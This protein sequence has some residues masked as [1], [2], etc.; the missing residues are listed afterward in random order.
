MGTARRYI[1]CVKGTLQ[2]FDEW[3]GPYPYDRITLVDPPHGGLRAGGMEYPDPH[4]SGH[5]VVHAQVR[6]RARIRHRT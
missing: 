5:G 6:A 2:K 4:Y 1:D 3:Y